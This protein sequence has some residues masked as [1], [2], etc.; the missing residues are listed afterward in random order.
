MKAWLDSYPLEGND[1]YQDMETLV[2]PISLEAYWCTFWADDAPYFVGKKERD[3]EDVFIA[4]S[5]WQTP[6]PG[7]ETQLGWK[8]LQEKTLEMYLRLRDIPFADHSYSKSYFSLLLK[9]DRGIIIK[10]T[11]TAEGAPYADTF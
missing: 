7:F 6:T 11:G 5:D 10:G 8:V 2:L 9:T 4:S 1:W 3:P